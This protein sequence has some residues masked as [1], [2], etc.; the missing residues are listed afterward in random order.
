MKQYEER[1]Y[2][3]QII[4]LSIGAIFLLRLFYVQVIN[5]EYTLSANNNVL[6]YMTEYPTRGLIYDRQGKLLVYNEAAYDLMVT[7]KQVKNLDTA[8]LCKILGI[9][10]AT[11]DVRMAKI[12]AYSRYKISPFEKQISI[13]TYAKLQEKLYKFSGFEVQARTLRKYPEKIAA[14][15]LGYIGE[16]ND[17]MIE[18]NPYYKDGDYA[19][20]GGIEKSYEKELR[21]KKGLRIV[22]VDVFNNI[23]GRYEDG[24][25]DSAAIAGSN[26]VS[27]LHADLQAYG[28]KL[29]QNKVG[30][31][32]AIEPKTGEIL[33]VITAPTY[34]P[35]L[36]VGRVRSQNYLKLLRADNKPLFNRALSASYPPGSTFKL[37]NAL[38]AQGEGVLKTSTTYPCSQGWPVMG[39]H[40]KC[41]KHPTPLDLPG[42]VQHSCNSYYA[43][44]FRSIIQNPAYKTT[45]DAYA[46]WR[47]YVESFGVGVPLN[48][49]LSEE[50]KG[51]V[52]SIKYYNKY[53]GKGH[54]NA[55]T[56]ISLSIGQGE[57]GITPLQMANI[58]STIANKG[59]F[60][61]PHIIK[62]VG[63]N[64]YLKK[65]FSEKHYTKVDSKYF[66]PIYEGMSKVAFGTAS[67]ARVEGITIA[68]KTG[69]AQNPHGKDHS[70]FVC[71]AP[72]EDPKIAIGIMVENSGFGNTY[73]VPIASLMIEKYL[74]DSISR[75]ELE[76]RMFEANL[77]STMHI[78][79]VPKN[80]KKKT[81]KKKSN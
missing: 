49:D 54:W 66:D 67:N 79:E 69:T 45:E 77:L 41:H 56:I 23:K 17:K 24:L 55:Y 61:T 80:N 5:K 40:P 74:R 59:W 75:P 38:I 37:V 30:G 27:T 18:K 25:Y 58:M 13:E 64:K 39:G 7:P 53:F 71:C 42:S 76:Q 48:T 26:I 43:F 60:V 62:A 3:I 46:A 28:E 31:C 68:G 34:D 36:L 81:T 57:L 16:V 6:R 14:H 19:G 50:K 10:R 2:I 1:K 63:E 11:F 73:A 70:L 8:D 65:E 32:V 22:K 78:K 51:N 35:N 12:K 72:A 9:A 52:P 29:M 4:F 44:V 20:M 21:G 47:S 33:A 15:V